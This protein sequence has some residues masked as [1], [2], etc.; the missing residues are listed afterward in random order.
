M[1]LLLDLV[2]N[3]SCFMKCWWF[4]FLF[5]LHW[6]LKSIVLVESIVHKFL[7][8]YSISLW[9]SI[10]Y[11]NFIPKNNTNFFFN[12]TNMTTNSTNL[13]RM[14]NPASVYLLHLSE[15]N[16]KIIQEVFGGSGYRDW[17]CAMI[18]ALSG[19]T[20]ANFC[21]WNAS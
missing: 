8:S 13:D 4:S 5:F 20:Q 19:K 6:L 16:Q 18:I 21:W 3:I 9:L 10:L 12:S 11:I 2:M 7:I 14:L 15:S 17:K 1:M